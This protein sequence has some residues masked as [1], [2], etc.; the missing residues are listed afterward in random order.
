VHGGKDTEH[1][2]KIQGGF[3]TK[4]QSIGQAKNVES[5]QDSQETYG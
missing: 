4:G 1:N 3:G 5:G 2:P